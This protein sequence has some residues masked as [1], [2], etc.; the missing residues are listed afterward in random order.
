MV[1]GYSFSSSLMMAFRCGGIF[2]L[3]VV[4]MCF[5]TKLKTR[6]EFQT[7]KVVQFIG[8]HLSEVPKSSHLYE[9]YKV[10]YSPFKSLGRIPEFPCTPSHSV[11]SLDAIRERL[12]QKHSKCFPCFRM[13]ELCTPLYPHSRHFILF[14]VFTPLWSAL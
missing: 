1:S 11:F 12:K 13:Q 6:E 9:K 7:F 14:L 10:Q 2:V 4:S 8:L 5:R 3:F